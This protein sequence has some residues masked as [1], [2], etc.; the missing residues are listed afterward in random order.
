MEVV[1]YKFTDIVEERFTRTLFDS[2]ERL[3]IT[4]EV[5]DQVIAYRKNRKIK[6]PDAVILAT[7]RV[8]N[9][10]LVTRNVSDFTDLD[11]SVS[12]INPFEKP[13]T[14]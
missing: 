1:G 5:A 11:S 10:Q 14:T 2:L 4:Q 12:I 6:L 13:K 8:Y 9:C 7:A 3:P